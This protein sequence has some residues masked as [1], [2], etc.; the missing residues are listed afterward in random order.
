MTEQ[1]AVRHGR[2]VERLLV[3]VGDN[4]F[5]ILDAE[6]VHIANG[7]AAATAHANHL[8]D[9]VTVGIKRF[10]SHEVHVAANIIYIHNHVSVKV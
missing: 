4:V 10:G 6:L 3:S 8:D 1:H 9:A 5:H 2:S 7:I